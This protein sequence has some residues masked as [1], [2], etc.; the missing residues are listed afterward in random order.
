MVAGNPVQFGGTGPGEGNVVAFSGGG[1]FSTLPGGITVSGT[2]PVTIRGNRFYGNVSAAIALDPVTFPTPNDPGDADTGANGKQNTPLIASIDY[3][4]PTVVHAIL[5]SAPSTTFAVDFFAN[6]VCL[7]KP[8]AFAQGADYVGTTDAATNGAGHAD[9]AFELPSPLLPGQ[10]VSATATDPSGN[11][12]EMSQT[13]LLRVAPRSGDGAGGTS[14]TLSG[15]A[16]EAG[17]IVAVGGVAAT[18]VVVTPPYT[19][20]ATMPAF[21]PGTFHDVVVT[22]PG[23]LQGKLTNGW[24]ADFLDVPPANI[25]HGDIVKL[26]A[27]QVTVGVGGGLYGVNDPV[28][29]QAMAVFVLKAEH[30]VCYTPPPCTPPGVFADVSCPSAFADWIEQMAAE[31]ITGGCG[32]GYFCPLQ[33][34]RRDQMAPFLLKA[35]HGPTYLPPAC[36]GIFLDVAVPVALRRLDRTAQDRGRDEWLRERK[37]LLSLQS[38]HARTDGHVPGQG[39]APS[40]GGVDAQRPRLRRCDGP[41]AAGRI[42]L[43]GLDRGARGRIRDL[44]LRRRVRLLPLKP[45]HAR[46]DGDLPREGPRPALRPARL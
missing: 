25:F 14:A 11:T 19:I 8:A 22:N 10:G 4:P 32:G 29:R 43:R 35:V 21:D 33:A 34:V 39:P 12:S 46:P 44:G 23:G 38:Q 15:Q 37:H 31:G 13:I 7:A 16:I 41:G 40:L 20:T 42:A 17:A 27:G 6:P 24:V 1:G 45:E 3:G 18:G 28:K 5:D 2:Q 9:I 36:A 30:G 26:V